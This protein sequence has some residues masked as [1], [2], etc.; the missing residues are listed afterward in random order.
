MKLVRNA[1]LT[2][3]LMGLALACESKDEAYDADKEA[4]DGAANAASTARGGATPQAANGRANESAL[5]TLIDLESNV[6]DDTLGITFT[7]VKVSTTN[8]PNYSP[9]NPQ[10]ADKLYLEVWYTLPFETGTYYYKTSFAYD[11]DADG[12]VHYRSGIPGQVIKQSGPS[13][14]PLSEYETFTV[15]APDMLLTSNYTLSSTLAAS[16]TSL[17][18]LLSDDADFPWGD[19]KNLEGL[20]IA[21]ASEYT[22]NN[23]LE[24]KAKMGCYI[25]NASSGI[26]FYFADVEQGHLTYYPTEAEADA[27]SDFDS[28]ET[29][30]ANNHEWHIAGININSK[31]IR[32]FKKTNIRLYNG[33]QLPGS[34]NSGSTTAP[35]ISGME[36]LVRTC[37]N[38]AGASGWFYP[39]FIDTDNDISLG[40]YFPYCADT[41]TL[42]QSDANSV[43]LNQYDSDCSW[44]NVGLMRHGSWDGSSHGFAS[45]TTIISEPATLTISETVALDFSAAA[46]N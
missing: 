3:S 12:W 31:V 19:L 16:S 20:K 43:P 36:T 33:R 29:V 28:D 45:S 30:L 39:I 44:D 14:E 17:A 42:N 11:V 40:S 38:S 22:I 41:D 27:N 13:D 23:D 10:Q 9:S 26:D 4:Q 32:M 8:E 2:L 24:T 37:N 1:I 7:R 46:N 25:Y 35:S 15:T 6:T 34:F 18:S 5:T 21:E